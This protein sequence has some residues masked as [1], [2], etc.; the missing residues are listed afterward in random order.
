[1]DFLYQA[2]DTSG[3]KVNLYISHKIHEPKVLSEVFRSYE[4][5]L[6]TTRVLSTFWWKSLNECYIIW[7]EN[8]DGKVLSGVVFEMTRNWQAGSILL[9]FTDPEYEKRGLS[10]LC[11]SYY[12]TKIKELGA[13][14][15]FASSSINNTDVLRVNKDGTMKNFVSGKVKWITYTKKLK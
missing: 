15:S 7:V 10:S 3:C 11:I 12:L 13:I 2:I 1:M 9:A 5:L 6:H 4:K 14:R 8:L